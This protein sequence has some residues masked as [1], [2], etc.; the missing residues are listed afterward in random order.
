[1]S[2]T[3]GPGRIKLEIEGDGITVLLR[4]GELRVIFTDADGRTRVEKCRATYY[5]ME[6]WTREIEAEWLE[7]D[8]GPEGPD[9]PREDPRRRSRSR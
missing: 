2:Y 9:P 6:T 7:P 4:H 8:V 5:H 3:R 1:M